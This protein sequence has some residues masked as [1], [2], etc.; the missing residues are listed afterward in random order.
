MA[1]LSLYQQHVD[2]LLGRTPEL[3]GLI[4]DKTQAAMRASSTDTMLATDRSL[5]FQVAEAVQTHRT[6]FQSALT[7]HIQQAIEGQSPTVSSGQRLDTVVNLD[8]LSLVDE[9]QA[10]QEIEAPEPSS[11]WT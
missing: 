8:E 9:D 7:R 2:Y 3:V 5:L 1:D 6:T 11:W 4:V 10:E